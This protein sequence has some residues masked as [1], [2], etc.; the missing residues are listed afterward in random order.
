[1]YNKLVYPE[2]MQTIIII[3]IINLFGE[4]QRPMYCY[5]GFPVSIYQIYMIA[6]INRMSSLVS[7]LGI[8]LFIRSF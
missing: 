3:V 7:L 1:M 8:Y 6:R 4:E 2:Y 5:Y